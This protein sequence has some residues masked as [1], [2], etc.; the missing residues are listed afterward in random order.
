M[1]DRTDEGPP[2]VPH[3]PHSF[4]RLQV[5]LCM[6]FV[7]VISIIVAFQVFTPAFIL[8]KGGPGS[9]TRVM[10]YFIVQNAF[11]FLRMGYA[12]AASFILLLVLMGLTLIQFRLLSSRTEI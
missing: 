4:R 8:T 9:A 5:L 1:L 12:S 10:P 7:A 3:T 11:D 2:E 6:L